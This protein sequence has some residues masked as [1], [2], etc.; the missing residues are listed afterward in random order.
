M[1]PPSTA[2]DLRRANRSAILRE[3]L[4][5]GESTRQGLAGRTGLSAA[6][7]GLVIADLLAEGLVHDVGTQ[8]SNGGRPRTLVR[9]APDGGVA[10]GVD[11]GE[12]GVRVEAFDLAWQRRADV[13]LAAEPG[14]PDP[15]AV[16]ASIVAAVGTV[17]DAA[18]TGSGELL[19]IGVSVPG[20]V[21]RGD[22][23]L[24]HAVGFGWEGVPLGQLLRRAIDAP[25]VVDNGAKTM[26][27]AEM[28]FGAGRG[29]ADAVIALLGIGV[30]AAVFT[31]GR[32]YRGSQSSAGEWGHAPIVV[33]GEPCRCGSRGCLEAYV[34]EL[35]LLRKWASLDPDGSGADAIDTD[36][37]QALFA[38]A[39]DD[40]AAGQVVEQ[41]AEHLGAGLATLIN[42]FNP[43]R[44]VLAGSVGLRLTPPI[45]DLIRTRAG[46]YSLRQ[47]F[48]SVEIAQGLLG[49]D[50]V[51]LGAATLVVDRLLSTGFNLSKSNSAAV[52]QLAGAIR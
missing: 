36:R 37:L 15:A 35:A 42:L 24:V 50:A 21:E 20:I 12:R 13:F 31:D 3:L 39:M 44:I 23:S 52:P 18:E 8:E 25:V 2:R 48:E 7:V 33:G 11:V 32:L 28:W 16:V 6:T 40:D 45:L 43:Q 22:D 41:M 19:G 46:R 34:G 9:M 27:Q 26:G 10:I 38:A 51:A 5:A 17:L 30:G 47:P 14:G 29:A 1:T 49:H 4:F